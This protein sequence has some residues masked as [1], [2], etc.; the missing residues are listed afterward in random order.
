MF[1]FIFS[2][3]VNPSCVCLNIC[4]NPAF[5]AT[6]SNN[7]Y[8]SKPNIVLV[9]GWIVRWQL[10]IM[11]RKREQHCFECNFYKFKHRFNFWQAISWMYCE[12]I[13]LT[14]GLDGVYI[15]KMNW[16][17]SWLLFSWCRLDMVD[18]AVTTHVHRTYHTNTATSLSE[19]LHMLSSAR[20]ICL[21]QRTCVLT[22]VT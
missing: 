17:I 8:I 5:L 9:C 22:E 11:S 7:G 20:D 2:L 10:Y 3:S 15:P 1:N 12:T 14:N 19:H 13:I 6:K 18:N 4:Y 21:N 16:I